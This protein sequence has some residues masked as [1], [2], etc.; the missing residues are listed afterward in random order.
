MTKPAPDASAMTDEHL[1]AAYSRAC[2]SL[3]KAQGSDP[4][5]TDTHAQRTAFE[6]WDALDREM[7]RRGLDRYPS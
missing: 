3:G 2:V 7:A 5:D 6:R 4:R 1:T